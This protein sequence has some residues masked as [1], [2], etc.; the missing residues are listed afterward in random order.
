MTGCLF[1]AFNRF[2]LAALL[3][4][5]RRKRLRGPDCKAL[6]RLK[7]QFYQSILYCSRPS[8]Q[9]AKDT[10]WFIQIF[11]I[12]PPRSRPFWGLFPFM[13]FITYL[14][15]N[16]TE[17]RRPVVPEHELRPFVSADHVN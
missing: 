5:A 1:M 6:E 10:V 9:P 12:Y 8:Y 3:A 14:H 17:Y 13:N 2:I 11:L 15:V 16:E 7:L 4:A